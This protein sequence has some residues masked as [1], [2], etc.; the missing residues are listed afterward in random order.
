MLPGLDV[1]AVR[2]YCEQR[3][4]PHVLGEIRV[5]LVE[6]RGAIT[7][8]ERRPPWREGYGD[9]W[10]SL[11]VARFR[12]TT[13]TGTWELFWRDRNEKWHR[14]DLLSPTADIR[15]LLDEVDRDPTGIFWG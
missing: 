8:Y 15:V 3:V 12:Y 6:S 14:Y 13:K 10:S 2:H 4:P 7:I 9:E 11:G 1:A 5:E